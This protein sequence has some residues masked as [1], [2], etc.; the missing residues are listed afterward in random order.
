MTANQL[1]TLEFRAEKL[2]WFEQVKN[3]NQTSW[4]TLVDLEGNSVAI[5]DAMVLDF[6]PLLYNLPQQSVRCENL[7]I[8]TTSGNQLLL[9]V[10]S[11]EMMQKEWERHSIKQAKSN[12]K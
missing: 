1:A 2:C 6:N 12:A 5:T 3:E 10:R 8:Q 9:I 4:Y 11:E 7:P